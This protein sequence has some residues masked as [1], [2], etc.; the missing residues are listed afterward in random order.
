MINSRCAINRCRL[1]LAAVLCLLGTA[2]WAAGS[3]PEL[4][5]E[6]MPSSQ[7]RPGMVGEA[8][9]GRRWEWGQTG[10]LPLEDALPSRDGMMR[11]GSTLDDRTIL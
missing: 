4:P 11:I 8:S 10:C 5:A 2:V 1:L 3:A 6:F 7:V 9:F